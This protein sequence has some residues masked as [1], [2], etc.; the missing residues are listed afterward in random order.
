MFEFIAFIQNNIGIIG[1]PESIFCS[2]S[3]GEIVS[4]ECKSADILSPANFF[5]ILNAL[6]LREPNSKKLSTAGWTFL[7][8]YKVDLI[9][10]IPSSVCIFIW[11]YIDFLLI[12]QWQMSPTRPSAS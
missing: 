3:P 6:P 2:Q 9:K 5:H 11:Q 8:I 4:N 12:H 1:I 7:T 10:S